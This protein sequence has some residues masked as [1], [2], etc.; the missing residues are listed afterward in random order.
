MNDKMNWKEFIFPVCTIVL[1]MG[2]PIGVV[3]LV[4]HVLEM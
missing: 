3:L 1:I 2:I 4:N